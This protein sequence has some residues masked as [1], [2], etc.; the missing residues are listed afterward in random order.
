MIGTSD[1]RKNKT[2]YTFL[3]CFKAAVY[4]APFAMVGLLALLFPIKRKKVIIENPRLREPKIISDA[5]TREGIYDVVWVDKASTSNPP[6]TRLVKTQSLRYAFELMTAGVWIDN[7]RKRGWV[8]K[9]KNQLYIQTWHSPVCIKKIEKDAIS[10]LTPAYVK[11]A[12]NDSKNI[13]YIVAESEWRKK[14]I[15]NSFWYDGP[16]IEAEFKDGLSN[17]NVD[18]SEVL[19]KLGLEDEDKILLYVPTFRKNGETDCYDINF[20]EL[21]Q[22]LDTLSNSHWVSLIRLHPNIADKV[23]FIEYN[24]RVVNCTLYQPLD[25]L[26]SVADMII[27]DFSGCLFHGYRAGKKVLLYA[28]DI[29]KYLSEERGVYFDFY[30]LPS[31]VASSYCELVENIKK[32]DEAK[33]ELSREKFVNQ[34]GYYENDACDKVMSIIEKHV[35]EE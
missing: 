31:P 21:V 32:L 20:N 35:K 6:G 24:E 22:E 18:R 17:H 33:Y 19:K 10:G 7:G 23:S 2:I 25:E 1:L 4:D 9:R 14:N 13:D 26:I 34:I 30:S 12:K 28:S 8:K 27:T 11:A 5:L 29:E 16:I 15:L 3:S